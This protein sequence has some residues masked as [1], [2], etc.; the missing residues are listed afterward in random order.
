MFGLE[1]FFA[2]FRLPTIHSV[3]SS[4]TKIADIWLFQESYNTIRTSV[5][6][7]RGRPGLFRL[8]HTLE[9]TLVLLWGDSFVTRL[10]ITLTFT[11]VCLRRPRLALAIDFP[12]DCFD[13]PG[14][15]VWLKSSAF[16]SSCQK[17]FLIDR[18]MCKWQ[19][20]NSNP[21]PLSSS[22]NT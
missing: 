18:K 11:G 3:F 17:I 12:R 4:R 7:F 8:L 20:Q 19:Q 2:I 6:F 22:T 16:C 14:G 1:H 15:G 5:V 21:Q 13:E 9:K 10:D